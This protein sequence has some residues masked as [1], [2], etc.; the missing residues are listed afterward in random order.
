MIRWLAKCRD[1][2]GRFLR[3]ARGGATAIVACAVAVLTV[4]AAAFVT[5]HIWLIDQRDV[6][7]GAS[8]AAA[9]AATMEM[10]RLPATTSDDDL[11]ERLEKVAKNHVLLNLTYLSEK[12]FT[13]AKETLTVQVTPDRAGGTATVVASADLGGTLF[14]RHLPA[15]GNYTGPEKVGARSGVESQVNPVEVVL[16]IDTSGSMIRDLSGQP[17]NGGS[18]SRMD[19]V[20]RAASDLVDILEPSAEKKIAVGVV[21]WHVVVRLDRPTRTEWSLRNWAQYPTSR[22]YEGMYDCRPEPGC[23]P[24]RGTQTL[25]AVATETWD[26][27]LD[28]HRLSDAGLADFSALEDSLDL[29][30]ASTFA[31]AFYPASYGIAY[32]C[33]TPPLPRNYQRQ[34]CYDAASV[35]ANKGQRTVPVQ[36]GCDKKTQAMLPLSSESTTIKNVIDSLT[37]VG[38]RT[39]SALGILWGQRLLSPE[40]RIVWGGSVHP[41]DR[42]AGVRKALVLLTDGADTQCRQDGDPA[43]TV[44]GGVSRTDACSLAKEQ[45][46]EIFV[47]AA[48]TPKQVSQGLAD[49]LRE[50]S[51]EDDN[52]DGTYVFLNNAD[53]E[54]LE[55]A[56]ADIANQL[57]TYRRI[58]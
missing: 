14:S 34:Q 7:K 50:C 57:L 21:P 37:P 3:D 46:T 53:A 52:P 8:N 18:D 56:F 45:G 31:Q 28:E 12:K 30:S 58:Y 11:R 20:K 51:S 36:F 17:S 33:L 9:F 43:C 6:L 27:C 1:L 19:I 15:L 26:G 23:V 38:L 32:Q 16:A 42:D 25:P 44:G 39:H 22:S 54:S 4:C 55:T 24:S 47:I 13:R 35:T 41:A 29:P 48:M 2:V 5:D 40:W 10:T 49:T